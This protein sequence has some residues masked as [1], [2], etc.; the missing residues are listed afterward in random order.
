MTANRF[1]WFVVTL[2]FAITVINYID[3]SAIAFAAHAI[4]QE[5]G[6]SSAQI[7]LVLGAFGIGYIISALFGGMASDRFGSKVTYGLIVLVWTLAIG[8]TGLAVGFVTLYAARITLGLAE[9]PSF[10]AMTGA[11]GTWL[12]PSE[13]ATALGGVLLAVPVALAIGSP[14]VSLL[15]NQFDWRTMFFILSVLGF[16]WLPFWLYYFSDRPENSRFVSDAESR[17]IAE[18]NR[19]DQ[20]PAKGRVASARDWRV[21]LTTPTLL[22]NYWAYFVF[23][24]YLFFFMTWMPE[25]LRKTYDLHITR[26]GLVAMLPWAASA[27][28]LYGF[29]RWSDVLLK[30]TSSLRVARSYQIAGTQIVAAIAIVPVALSG[31]IYIAVTGI[32]IAVAASMAGNAAYYAV[33]TDLTPRLAGT[34]MGIMTIWFAASGFLAPVVTGYALDLTGDFAPAF[35]L[36]S[37]LAASSV[38]GVIL[39]HRPD[40]DRDRLA[41]LEA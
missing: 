2:L 7:G 33:V 11:V 8:W 39:F 5:F 15:I 21:L 13:R 41:A 16:L 3:R 25:Y 23:G 6:L 20:S 1:R 36:I 4:Q 27:I 18:A 22:S 26:V 38:V 34:A 9:G 17:R 12:T 32:T 19:H 35:W 29:G 28:A 40:R 31:N 10:P 24:Y 30:R 37:V 14:I